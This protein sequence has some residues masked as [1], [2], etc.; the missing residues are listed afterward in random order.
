[1]QVRPVNEA[2]QY[3]NGETEEQ[4]RE[5]AKIEYN[6]G[7]AGSILQGIFTGNSKSSIG[8]NRG[9][10]P[11]SINVLQK[12]AALAMGELAHGDNF[13]MGDVLKVAIAYINRLRKYSTDGCCGLKASSWYNAAINDPDSERGKLYREYMAALG[14]EDYK[15]DK[16]ANELAGNDPIHV[17]RV[18]N[19]FSTISFWE[20][21]STNYM[22]TILPSN[23][24]GQGFTGD[25]NKTDATHNDIRQF[26]YLISTGKIVNNNY[27]IILIPTNRER[28][29]QTTFLYDEDF[30]KDFFIK[31]PDQRANGQ[32][33]QY[34]YNS[35]TGF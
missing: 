23:I 7:F 16:L 34:N 4:K 28:L 6:R 33:P 9:I 14:N 13:T 18:K 15:N 11:L 31:H 25:I 24:F 21:M 1:M 35:P 20:S 17:E 12:I 29:Y 3:M 19:L 30:I 22:N 27:L 26:I 5:Q 10:G 2:E 32:A 8:S